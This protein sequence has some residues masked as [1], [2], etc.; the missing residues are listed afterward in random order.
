MPR[1]INRFIEAI[2]YTQN[3][4]DYLSSALVFLGAYYRLTNAWLC[5][6][7]GQGDNEFVLGKVPW[8]Y[9]IT[10]LGAT[11]NYSVI[12]RLVGDRSQYLTH[13]EMSTNDYSDQNRAC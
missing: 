3:R 13:L 11:K 10:T 8:S 4:Q 6:N 1:H 5:P 9:S 7:C 12:K 2:S